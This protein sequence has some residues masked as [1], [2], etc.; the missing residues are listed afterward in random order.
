MAASFESISFNQLPNRMKRAFILRHYFMIYELKHLLDGSFR[1]IRELK[2]I[3]H[4]S[5]ITEL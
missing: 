2:I 4:Y 3:N 1:K 5:K